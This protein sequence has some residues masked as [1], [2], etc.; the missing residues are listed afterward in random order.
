[1]LFRSLRWAGR[2]AAE[3][4][5]PGRDPAQLWDLAEV[6]ALHDARNAVAQERV[7]AHGT[8]AELYLLAVA[9]PGIAARERDW[10]ALAV[11]A[12]RQLAAGVGGGAFEL[13]ST[14][15][16]FQRYGQWYA[17]LC[18]QPPAWQ[19]KLLAIAQAVVD[20]LPAVPDAEWDYAR[21]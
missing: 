15:R 6:Q 13:L 20:E 3:Q 10:P 12:A 17:R 21:G 2:P 7:W 5:Q 18:A 14:R 9:I 19:D 4:D 1:M 16:Q 8:L 11:S